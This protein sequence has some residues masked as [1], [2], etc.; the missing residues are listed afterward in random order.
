MLFPFFLFLSSKGH[1]QRD[2][3]FSSEISLIFTIILSPFCYYGINILLTFTNW[4]LVSCA[5]ISGH[6]MGCVVFF[7]GL[8][9]IFPCLINDKMCWS[10]IQCG[11]APNLWRVCMLAPRGCPVF[12][13]DGKDYTWIKY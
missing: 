8:W 1:T 11:M 6:Y 5:L 9:P 12:K 13:I 10:L 7:S 4:S 2:T 3:F